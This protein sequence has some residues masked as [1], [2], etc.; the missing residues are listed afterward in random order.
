[1]DAQIE[2]RSAKSED[3]PEIW[4]IIQSVISSGGT[5]VFNPDSPENKMREYWLG[6]DK[7]CYVACIKGKVVGTF[8][9]KDNQPDLGSHVSNG[10]YMTHPDQQ[11]KGIGYTMGEASLSIARELGY[12][13]MQFNIVIE[14]N[15]V[16]VRLWKKLGFEIVGKVP[17]AFKHRSDGNSD[18]LIMWRSL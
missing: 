12:E 6:N 18:I 10:S 9:L 7:Y 5:Y 8:I 1:M 16:A 4:E 11:G 3:W 2:I 15:K 14:K 13:A 17:G